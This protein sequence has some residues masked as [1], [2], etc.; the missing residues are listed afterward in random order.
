MT[1]PIKTSSSNGWSQRR[2]RIALAV[3]A[4]LFLA[5]VAGGYVLSTLV[6]PVTPPAVASDFVPAAPE[7]GATAPEISLSQL[8]NGS[9]GSH[10][11]LGA[12]RGH[13]IVVNFW[14]TWCQPCKEEFPVLDAAF[15]KYRQADDLHVIGINIQDG[16]TPEQVQAFIGEMGVLFPIWLTGQEDFS[17]EKAYKIQA[18]PTTVFI[19]R[20]GIIRQIRIGGPLTEAYLEQQLEKIK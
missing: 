3:L 5:I 11:T 14:A 20:T 15:R 6:V 10:V 9:V 18:M 7:I 17:V 4:V 16:S 13:P 8:E 1:T 12:L 2:T 19:D